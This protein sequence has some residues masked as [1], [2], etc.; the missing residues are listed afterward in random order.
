MIEVNRKQ[1]ARA[2]D[3]AAAPISSRA[4]IPVLGSVKATA[5]GVLRLEATDLDNWTCA[6]LAYDGDAAA[7]FLLPQP[8]M[9]RSAINA[10]GDDV[11]SVEPAAADEPGYNNKV[12]VRSGRLDCDL[13]HLPE[14]DFPTP[15]RISIEEFTAT[16]GEAELR[17]IARVLRAVSTEETRYYL[18][19]ICVSH[20]DGWT[21]RFAATNGHVLMVVDVP[22]PDAVGAIPDKTI[23]P[24]GWLKLIMARFAKAKNGARFTYGQRAALNSS[25]PDLPLQPAGPRI[26]LS[27]DL[28]GIAYSVT[29]K[30]I[31][32]HYPDYARVIPTSW[33]HTSTFRCSD[34]AQAIHT[35]SSLTL[36]KT[37]AVKLTFPSGKICVELQSPD[38]GRSKFDFDAEHDVPEGFKIGFN[39][40]YL[41]D[42][43]T[44]I[45]GD[46]VVMRLAEVGTDASAPA[47]FVDPADPAFTGVL[48]PC[49][50]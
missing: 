24:N 39:G 33:E 1:F 43:L 48:M 40:R 20:V 10:A 27:A 30:L 21:Y 45:S 32:G 23:I 38:I 34:L 29:G 47:M 2:V 49:R 8:R 25:G 18:N 15:D 37:R 19:G 42:I 12:I 14:S 35:L 4:T 46:E 5:N 44:G 13:W 41:L 3:L 22:L 28:D 50:V 11:V 17:Q 9:L 16:L 7:E 6:E 26:R 31:D 36:S